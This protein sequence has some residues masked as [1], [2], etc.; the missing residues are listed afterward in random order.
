MLIIP[1]VDIRAGSCVRLTKGDFKQETVYSTDP[2]EM[3][4]IWVEKGAKRIHVIDLDGAFSGQ[5]H[6]LELAGKMKR[7]LGCEVQFGGGLREKDTVK[8][9]LDLGIDKLIRGTAA[10]ANQDWVKSA[11][12]WNADRLILAT[13][14]MNNHGPSRM[15]GGRAFTVKRLRNGKH[16]FSEQFTDIS[17][18]GCDGPNF[19]SV[20]KVVGTRECVRVRRYHHSAGL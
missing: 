14:A 18:D 19:E 13:D 12:D 6:H 4:R 10:L 8:K 5:P 3:A 1:A 17:R 11:L 16:G 15:A 2:V 7:E 20:R 9:A